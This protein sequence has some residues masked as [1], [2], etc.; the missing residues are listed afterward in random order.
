MSDD[1]RRPAD[2]DPRPDDAVRGS[3]APKDRL[4]PSHRPGEHPE[5]KRSGSSR[6]TMK[7]LVLGLVLLGLLYAAITIGIAATGQAA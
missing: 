4:D 2:D 6:S 3:T 5:A 1:P 7:G